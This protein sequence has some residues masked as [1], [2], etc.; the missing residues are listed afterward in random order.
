MELKYNEVEGLIKHILERLHEET[1]SVVTLEDEDSLDDTIE[2]LTRA[3]Q[4]CNILK[5]YWDMSEASDTFSFN[6]S[7]TRDIDLD[8]MLGVDN[9]D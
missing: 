5:T 2:E 1:M 6:L 3:L 4:A 7:V 9:D 8:A